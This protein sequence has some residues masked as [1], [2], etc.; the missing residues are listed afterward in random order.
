MPVKY[1]MKFCLLRF[2]F[3]VNFTTLRRTPRCAVRANLVYLHISVQF[4]F[5]WFQNW[6][7]PRFRIELNTWGKDFQ[8]FSLTIPSEFRSANKKTAFFG[9][10]AMPHRQAMMH[11]GCCWSLLRKTEQVITAKRIIDSTKIVTVE[12]TRFGWMKMSRGKGV[13]EECEEVQSRDEITSSWF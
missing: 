9:A 7:W 6:R 5:D 4:H 3:S 13:R 11:T 8:N 1:S 2:Y 10:A 12:D